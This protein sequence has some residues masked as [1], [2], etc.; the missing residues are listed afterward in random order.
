[1]TMEQKAIR[2]RA[3]PLTEH[4]EGRHLPES[5]ETERLRERRPAFERADGQRARKALTRAG[6]EG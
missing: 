6:A 3:Q 4:A 5:E 2:R 1:M